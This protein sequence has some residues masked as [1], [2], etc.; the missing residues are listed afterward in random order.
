MISDPNNSVISI[1]IIEDD[2]L[3]RQALESIFPLSPEFKLIGIWRNAESAIR[4]IPRTPPDIALIDIH[5]PG[6]NGIDCIRQLKKTNPAI[7]FLVFTGY[8]EEDE[9]VFEALKAGATGY[10]LKSDGPEL[11]IKSIKELHAGG[12]PMSRSIARKIINFFGRPTMQ[13]GKDH[14]LTRRE[15]EVLT[16]LAEGKMYK[17]VAV[18][19]GITMETTKKHVKH[20]YNKLEVQN[21]M[22]AVNKWR[23]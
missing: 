11:L 21:R 12:S 14:P 9:T 2:P 22:E 6:M 5:L 15:E 4:E 3:Y 19:L 18:W 10:L 20:I 23:S 8:E 7:Q 17:E 13:N 16:L 1:G